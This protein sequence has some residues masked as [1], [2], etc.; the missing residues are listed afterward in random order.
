M[1]PCESVVNAIKTPL[2]TKRSSSV[3]AGRAPAEGLPLSPLWDWPSAAHSCSPK[4]TPPQQASVIRLLWVFEG[5]VLSLDSLAKSSMLQ[6]MQLAEVFVDCLPSQQLTL[7]TLVS[8]SSLPT[9]S[10][11]PR[12][13]S[14]TCA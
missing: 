4:A 2:Q 1:E 3:A 8:F 14:A 11:F 10:A 5:S 9:Q 13:Q 6:T 7:P 12:P